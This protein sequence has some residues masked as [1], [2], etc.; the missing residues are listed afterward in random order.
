[1]TNTYSDGPGPAR[2]E[3]DNSLE[4]VRTA[5][6]SAGETIAKETAHFADAAKDQVSERIEGGKAAAADAL[7]TFADA[8]RKAG[9]ELGQND[10]TMVAGLVSQAA[11]GLESLSRTVSQKQ[12]K[13][14]MVA[15]RDFGRANPAAFMAGAVLAGVALGRFA[16]SS[17]HHAESAGSPQSPKAA[18]SASEEPGPLSTFETPGVPDPI[19]AD[20]A[21]ALQGGAGGVGASGD[22]TDTSATPARFGH[23][24]GLAGTSGAEPVDD[25]G[26]N[27]DVFKGGA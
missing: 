21:Q 24:G 18:S 17:T 14:L 15:V 3:Q 7:A 6:L 13:D 22:T 20:M 12:P 4:Q 25:L 2:A 1:M 11:E 27:R 26:E 10:Q 8:V 19:A 16:R 9:E 5:A 23:E